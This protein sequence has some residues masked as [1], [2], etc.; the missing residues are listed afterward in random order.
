M[1]FRLSNASWM[2]MCLGAFALS[3]SVDASGF[4]NRISTFN[5]CELDGNCLKDDETSAEILE[6]FTMKDGSDCV[7]FTD[8]PKN[9]M[10]FVDI[11]DPSNP[12]GLSKVDL[13]GE[14]TT[15]KVVDNKFGE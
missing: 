9:Q 11:S 12:K 6:T 1:K 4:F 5:V 14:P 10:G 15:V 3:T 13:P 8:S 2:A 7:V